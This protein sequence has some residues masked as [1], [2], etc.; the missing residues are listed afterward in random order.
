MLPSRPNAHAYLLGRK[1]PSQFHRKIRSLLSSSC[2]F[3]VE[4]ARMVQSNSYVLPEVREALAGRQM[5]TPNAWSGTA[6]LY[7]EQYR[8]ASKVG[9]TH[10]LSEQLLVQGQNR[11]RYL[12]K[13]EAK[14]C[15][16]AF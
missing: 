1:G 13:L 15:L 12:G 9:D 8:V 7:S 16:H 2:G 11:K 10:T 6:V 4:I 3:Y 14:Q 5:A